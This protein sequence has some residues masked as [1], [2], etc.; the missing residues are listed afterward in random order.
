MFIVTGKM[1]MDI[2]HRQKYCNNLYKNNLQKNV[3]RQ[4]HQKYFHNMS[5]E[6]KNTFIM[7]FLFKIIMI[8]RA[9]NGEFSSQ[10]YFIFI[11]T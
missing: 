11:H 5:I 7:R 3:S 8:S 4:T 6:Y 9:N 10:L 1:F 2:G